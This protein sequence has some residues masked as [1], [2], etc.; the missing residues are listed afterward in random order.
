MIELIFHLF[1]SFFPYFCN[2]ALFLL[3]TNDKPGVLSELLTPMSNETN[4]FEVNV[5]MGIDVN[6]IFFH[7][8]LR[9]H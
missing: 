2:T 1:F 3:N 9:R 8:S 7:R 4:S 6:G 5:V